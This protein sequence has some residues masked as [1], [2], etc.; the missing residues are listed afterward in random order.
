[1]TNELLHI[2]EEKQIINL[3]SHILKDSKEVGFGRNE[4]FIIHLLK[5]FLTSHFKIKIS[6][7]L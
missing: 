4:S 2:D 5:K 7:L 6:S 3:F 1:M